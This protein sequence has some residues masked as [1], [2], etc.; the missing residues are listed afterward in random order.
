MPSSYEAPLSC[1]I[2]EYV[3]RSTPKAYARFLDLFCCSRLG[4]IA[5]GIPEGTKRGDDIKSTADHPIGLGTTQHAGGREM[6]LAFADPAVFEKRFGQRFNAA[7]DGEE[8]LESALANPNCH[9]ILINSATAEVSAVIRRDVIEQLLSGRRTT[10]QK[11]A[12]A[13]WKFW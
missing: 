12:R 13:W 3:E 7:I 8:L 9:G 11:S 10:N 2:Q 4:V 6:V 5:V 1:L